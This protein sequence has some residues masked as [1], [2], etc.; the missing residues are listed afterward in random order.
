MATAIHPA[1]VSS[2]AVKNSSITTGH[3]ADRSIA[4]G[5]GGVV[6]RLKIV[7]GMSTIT[8]GGHSAATIEVV[9]G[10]G[11]ITGIAFH[12]GRQMERPTRFSIY[13]ARALA[14]NDQSYILL[15][16]HRRFPFH[17]QK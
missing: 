15:D 2:A 14:S 13:H 9:V 1:R 16:D 5:T 11:I 6:Q 7:A 3:G 17:R 10:A 8:R 4:V 12:S